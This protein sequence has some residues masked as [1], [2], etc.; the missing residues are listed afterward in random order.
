MG[1]GKG[2]QGLDFLATVVSPKQQWLLPYV[3][4]GKQGR[5]GVRLGTGAA[6]HLQGGEGQAGRDPVDEKGFPD[7]TAIQKGN[8]GLCLILLV[9]LG[10]R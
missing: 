7:W 4:R 3:D 6:F 2:Q 5:A 10:F 9:G 8:A 1:N